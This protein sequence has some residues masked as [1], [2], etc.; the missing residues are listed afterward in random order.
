MPVYEL[1]GN[2]LRV[3]FAALKSALIEDSKVPKRQ[4]AKNN[5]TLD[6]TL[7]LKIIDEIRNDPIVTMDQLSEKTGIAR[8]TLIRYMSFLRENNR[9]ERIGG[10]RYGHWQINE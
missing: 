7:A 3:H 5:G 2:G 9:I 1:L 10:K 6:D 4:S 8:R